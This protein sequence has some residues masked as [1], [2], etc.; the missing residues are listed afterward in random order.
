MVEFLNIQSDQLE[1][2]PVMLA[3]TGKTFLTPYLRGGVISFPGTD[4]LIYFSM[5]GKAFFIRLLI[6]ENMTLSTI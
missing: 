5:A 3:V 4:P 6:A 1:A 2:F